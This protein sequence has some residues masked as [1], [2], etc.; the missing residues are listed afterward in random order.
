M[1]GVVQMAT[2]KTS[3]KRIIGPVFEQPRARETPD[4]VVDRSSIVN[5]LIAL[6]VRITCELDLLKLITRHQYL[7]GDIRF[8]HRL[9]WPQTVKNWPKTCIARKDSFFWCEF[10]N[11]GI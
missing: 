8:P 1:F 10:K 3:I 7:L 4:E 2:D 6:D 11:R 5:C 9:A